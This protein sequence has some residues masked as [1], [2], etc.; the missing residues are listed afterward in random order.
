MNNN[1]EY[2]NLIINKVSA[3]NPVHAKNLKMYLNTVDKDIILE[4]ASIFKDYCDFLKQYFQITDDYI[5]DSYMHLIKEMM[6]EQVYFQRNS[7]YRYS[8]LREADEK[9]YSNREYMLK[10]MIGL[11]LS[12]FLWKNHYAI[13]KFFISKV[14]KSQGENY[15]EIGC[16]HG[17]FFI[18]AIKNNG[19]KSFNA[20]D[21]SDTSIDLT[22]NLLL[23][24]FHEKPQ[25]VSLELKNIFDLDIQ[26]GYDFISMGE[27]LEHVETPKQL[28]DKIFTLLSDSGLFFVSTCVNCPAKDHIFL[29]K[30]V[31]EIRGLFRESGFS[32]VDEFVC[33]ADNIQLE[34]AEKNKTTINYAAF[35]TKGK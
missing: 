27:V 35:L 5:A 6:I 17:L 12:Q 34:E 20:I 15:L 31:E 1:I 23:H 10:Y 8:T 22:E 28:L 3:K 11:A 9:V 21:L 25:N 24:Y 16:G 2:L 13:F 32:V 29:F 30:N 4:C 19:F 26:C 7:Q 14:A 18:E 33:A